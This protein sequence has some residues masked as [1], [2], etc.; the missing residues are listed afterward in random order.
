MQWKRRSVGTWLVASVFGGVWSS[1]ASAQTF[2]SRPLRLV[3]PFPPGGTGDVQA[4]L[5]GEFMSRELGQ[6]VVVENKPGAGTVIGTHQVAQAAPDGHTLL[7]M[8]NSFV[9]NAKLRGATLPYAGLK[10]F[11]P[12]ACLTNSPQAIAVNSATP[13]R[14]F[15]EWMDAVK[16]K[17]DTV[18]YAAFGPATAQHIAAEILVR[19]AGLRMTYVPFAGGAP[20]VN[21]ALAG[22]VQTVLANVN[23]IQAHAE[24]GKLRMLAVT[25]AQRLAALPNVPTVSESG[26]P[27]YEAAA[28]FGLCAPAG[29]PKDVVARLARAASNAVND[30]EVAKRLVAAGLQPY[31]MDSAR[32]AAHINEQ[33]AL[34]SK[35]ID[36]AGIKA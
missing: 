15:R 13:W 18:A 10:A 30:A 26:V 23:E 8:A 14:T 6:P 2:P 35:V 9:I 19:A 34:Y 5:I 28:W 33:F 1:G 24:A 32:F 3:V 29:T 31:L 22:H 20:A 12:V 11:E 17:P 16:A 4:R 21:A 36:E 27:G 25:T 7:L